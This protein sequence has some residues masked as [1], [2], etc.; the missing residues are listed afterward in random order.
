MTFDDLERTC[1]REIN[2]E[3]GVDSQRRVQGWQLLAYANE[4]EVEACI[5]ARL[6]VDSISTDVCRITVEPGLAV[7]TYDPRI[8]LILR[9][10][11]AGAT[12][13]LSK[14][15]HTIMDERLPGWEDQS[16]EVLAFVTGMNTGRIMMYKKPAEAGT[17]NLTVVRRPLND[18]AKAGDSPEI[19]AVHH[20]SLILWMKHKVYNNQDSE[21]FDKNRANVHLA[22]FEQKFGQ[23]TAVP[24]DVFDAMQIPE[25]TPDQYI[26]DGYY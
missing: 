11:M 2:D 12:R 13:P 14:V 26:S 19:N 24:L 15:S 17:L 4:A 7:Y 9:G 18:M 6:L 5:R 10:R 23:R 21:L 16:G 25:F 20:P 3:T 8:L 22:M 1:R